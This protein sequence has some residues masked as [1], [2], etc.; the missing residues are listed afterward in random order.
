MSGEFITYVRI[1]FDQE[2]LMCMVGDGHINITNFYGEVVQ[3]F[4]GEHSLYSP[5]LLDNSRV[6]S[7]NYDDNSVQITDLLTGEISYKF[8]HH[9]TQGFSC[10][11]FHT[12]T[13]TLFCGNNNGKLYVL[14]TTHS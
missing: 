1:L 11:A 5:T 14:K 2:R 6:V 13:R 10:F 4:D 3:S 8:H 7:G 12:Q 9:S